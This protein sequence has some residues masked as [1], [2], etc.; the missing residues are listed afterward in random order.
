MMSAL[1]LPYRLTWVVG[2]M[3][4]QGIPNPLTWVRFLHSLPSWFH[5]ETEITTLYE[6]VIISS[7]LVGTTILGRSRV[8]PEAVCKTVANAMSVRFTLGSLGD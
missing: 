6:S 5:G 7:N 2:L 1:W 4:R 8:V 3:V